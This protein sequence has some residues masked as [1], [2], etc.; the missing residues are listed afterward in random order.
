MFSSGRWETEVEF[1]DVRKVESLDITTTLPEGCKVYVGYQY[2]SNNVNWSTEVIVEGDVAIGSVG[3]YWKFTL[4]L[5]GS[6]LISPEVISAVVNYIEPSAFYLWLNSA[7]CPKPIFE[8]LF[9]AVIT[10][11][12]ETAITELAIWHGGNYEW[13]NCDYVCRYRG[14][15]PYNLWRAIVQSEHYEECA[16]VLK[17]SNLGGEPMRVHDF[18]IGYNYRGVY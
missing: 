6:E 11:Y 9:Q 14:G 12:P 16:F 18:S 17:F 1:D 8:A 13:A 7:N 15:T 2:S 4:Y 5:S 3:K 10:P